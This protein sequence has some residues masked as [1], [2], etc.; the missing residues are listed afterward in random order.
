MSWMRLLYKENEA[1]SAPKRQKQA[2]F[3]H[4]IYVFVQVLYKQWETNFLFHWYAVKFRKCVSN[5]GSS[6]FRTMLRY[7]FGVMPFTSRNALANLLPLS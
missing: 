7:A 6:L 1:V 3:G 4:C 2:P 5:Y